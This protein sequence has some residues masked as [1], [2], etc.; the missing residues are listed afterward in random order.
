[1]VS[2]YGR[3]APSTKGSGVTA[4]PQAWA[5]TCTRTVTRSRIMKARGVRVRSTVLVCTRGLTVLSTKVS[6]TMGASKVKA[7][8]CMHQ[9]T[10]TLVT[11]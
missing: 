3:V 8:T 10:D 4:Y 11:G 5:G 9:V 6:I 7:R 2:T 1:M